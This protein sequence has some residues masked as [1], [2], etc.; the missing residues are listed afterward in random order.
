MIKLGTFEQWPEARKRLLEKDLTRAHAELARE[1]CQIPVYPVGKSYE[2]TASGGS[3]KTLADL[4]ER[5]WVIINAFNSST[6]NKFRLF[7]TACVGL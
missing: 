5:H 7:N 6:R 1:R 2:F 3:I 4:F